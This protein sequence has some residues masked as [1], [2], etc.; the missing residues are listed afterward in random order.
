MT[1]TLWTLAIVL[2]ALAGF[3]ARDLLHRVRTPQLTEPPAT[4]VTVTGDTD[5]A[6]VANLLHRLPN[7]GRTA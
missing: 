2:A 1:A 4:T 5:P 7:Q 6:V 3:A